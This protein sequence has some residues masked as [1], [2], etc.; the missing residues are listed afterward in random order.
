M[1][2][3]KI[4]YFNHAWYTIWSYHTAAKQNTVFIENSEVPHNT[5]NSA[6]GHI[7]N[8]FK[9][10]NTATT[11]S[12]LCWIWYHVSAWQA[13]RKTISDPVPI[14]RIV[15]SVDIMALCCETHG[16]KWS[17]VQIKIHKSPSK[18]AIG[19]VLRLLLLLICVAYPVRAASCQNIIPV[20]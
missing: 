9:A 2:N 8:Y 5:V 16:Y 12:L 3:G 15:P 14:A 10:S 4:R 13:L 11:F 17:K 7:F 18:H 6:R 1:S 20:E 19:G